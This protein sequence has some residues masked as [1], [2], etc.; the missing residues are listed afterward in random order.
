MEKQGKEDDSDEGCGIAESPCGPSLRIESASICKLR[1]GAPRSEY[2]CALQ[3]ATMELRSDREIVVRAV[4]K[5]GSALQF[6]ATEDW[7]GARCRGATRGAQWFRV[8]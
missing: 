6:A 8:N 4:S 3:H 2:G 7:I 5:N 1:F